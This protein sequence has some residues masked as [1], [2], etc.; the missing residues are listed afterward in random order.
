VRGTN[1][2]LGQLVI[3][4]ADLRTAIGRVDFQGRTGIQIRKDD[5]VLGNL[6]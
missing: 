1:E 5:L 6:R 4:K 3:I 2:Y